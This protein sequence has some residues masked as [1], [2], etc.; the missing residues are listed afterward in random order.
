LIFS[1]VPESVLIYKGAVE[2]VYKPA[3]ASFQP[4]DEG[5]FRYLQAMRNLGIALYRDEPEN[6]ERAYAWDIARELIG[7]TH[8]MFAKA[9]IASILG[10]QGVALCHLYDDRPENM[11]IGRMVERWQPR[12]GKIAILVDTQVPYGLEFCENFHGGYRPYAVDSADMY[13]S[14]QAIHRQGED[15]GKVVR[16]AISKCTTPATLVK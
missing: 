9:K 15:I 11:L 13:F 16:S 8:P 1:G 7:N 12:H 2:N 4:M 10:S 14:V 6:D 3:I 5:V